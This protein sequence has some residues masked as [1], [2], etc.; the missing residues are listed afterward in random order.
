[1]I[2]HSMLLLYDDVVFEDGNVC[3]SIL[4]APGEDYYGYE[5][6]YERWLPVH[7]VTSIMLSVI[8]MLAS[9]NDE[10]PANVVAARE[11]RSEKDVFQKKVKAIVRKSQEN[12]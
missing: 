6:A 5:K 4:H 10:S 7:T 8:S 12:L 1:M 9:P 3:I 11:F 2:N